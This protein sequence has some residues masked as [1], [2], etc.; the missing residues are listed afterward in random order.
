M[1][2]STGIAGEIGHI[3]LKKDGRG[4]T[5]G[6]RGCFEQY[7]SMTALM[8]QVKK[9]K[10]HTLEDINGI[11]IFSEARKGNKAIADCINEFLEY[12]AIGITNLIHIFNP[13]AIII[14]GGV[15]RQGGTIIKP[16]I[17]KVKRMTMPG[18]MKNIVINTAGL[19]NDAGM[20]GAVK[21]FH[22]Q[23]RIIGGAMNGYR[24]YR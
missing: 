19:S 8:D 16:L 12:N 2:G 9:I 17:E 20:I 3:V 6:N 22:R 15:S 18:F 23:S 10:G 5:C 1:S 13:E 7:G 14:G 21:K 4:C 24:S 11:T